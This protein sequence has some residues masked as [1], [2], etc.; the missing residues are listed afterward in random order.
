MEKVPQPEGRCNDTDPMWL[1]DRLFF[2]SDRDGEFN[3]YAY[4]RATK[5]VR[6]LTR[7]DDF[8]VLGRP[9]PPAASSTS[10]RATCTCSTPRPARP[11]ACSIGVSADLV[12]RRPRYAKGTK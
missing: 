8:P 10:R 11:S 9:R 4:D 3:L 12:E 5:A 6:R 1:G 2:R 7:H